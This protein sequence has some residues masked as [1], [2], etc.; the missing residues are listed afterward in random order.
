MP[1]DPPVTSR[2]FSAT[3]N[4]SWEKASVSMRKGMP[5]IRTQKNPITAAPPAA[6]ATPRHDA[7]P[8]IDAELRAEHGDCISAQA[9]KRRVAERHQAGEAKEQIEAHGEDRENEYLGDQRARII[10]QQRMAAGLTRERPEPD[11]RMSRA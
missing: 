9:E 7:D 8:G 2:H 6:R 3:E 11:D 1:S 5:A 10:W 4:T